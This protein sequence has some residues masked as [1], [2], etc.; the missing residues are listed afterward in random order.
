MYVFCLFM[1][2][3]MSLTAGLFRWVV[4]FFCC[5]LGM[6]SSSL[7]IRSW[8]QKTWSLFRGCFKAGRCQFLLRNPE[9]TSLTP[10]IFLHLLRLGSRENPTGA[11]P[12]FS[13]SCASGWMDTFMWQVSIPRQALVRMP[14]LI[15]T[16]CLRCGLG[17]CPLMVV[18]HLRIFLLPAPKSCLHLICY[19]LLQPF[20]WGG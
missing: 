8:V 13:A 18:R 20:R 2:I 3:F 9:E 14:F 15:L 6:S 4:F 11:W 19:R 5:L 17:S 16:W 1:S 7:S 12:D 10:F